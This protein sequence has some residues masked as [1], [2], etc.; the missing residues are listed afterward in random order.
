[1]LAPG[2]V[3]A[4]DIPPLGAANDDELGAAQGAL[5]QPGQQVSRLSP[6]P[7]SDAR[8]PR[9]SPRPGRLVDDRIALPD[10]PLCLWTLPALALARVGVLDP[11]RAVPDHAP[12]VSLVL[13]QAVQR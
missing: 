2:M 12:D 10:D 4:A 7:A 11:P 6:A 8:K 3:G 1:M 13:K 9:L 5:Q